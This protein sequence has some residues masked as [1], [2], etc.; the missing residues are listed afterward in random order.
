MSVSYN[1]FIN[2]DKPFEEV[3]SSVEKILNC[4]MKKSPYTEDELYYT[5]V[6][7]LGIGL[8]KEH[9]FEGYEGTDLVFSNYQ[10]YINIDYIAPSF[11]RSYKGEW[12]PTMAVLLSDMLCL[13]L[14]CECLIVRNMASVIGKFT[15]DEQ[16]ITLDQDI[17]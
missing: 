4:Q 5:T 14:Q 16:T 2:T 10:F 3:K 17:A 8:H 15:P 7:G 11:L 12:E 9:S 1:I 13:N 6:L